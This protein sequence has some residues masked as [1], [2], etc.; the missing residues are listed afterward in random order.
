MSFTEINGAYIADTARV[1]GNVQL[2]RD[3]SVW[4][5][6]VIRGD[7]A[8]ISIGDGTNVQENAVLH[9]DYGKN[10][11]IG[12]GVTIGHGAIIHGVFVGEGSLIG[13]NATLLNDSHVGKGCLIAAGAVVPPGMEVPD[14]MLVMGLPGQVARPVSDKEKAYLKYAA[15]HYVENVKLHC[16]QPDDPRVRLFGTQ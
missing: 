12:G 16:S 10:Q 13:M 5:G 14:G 8:S 4:Y 11:V 3:V 7:I 2:G 9:C 15:E 1:V 6:A